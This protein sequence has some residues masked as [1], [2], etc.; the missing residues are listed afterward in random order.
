MR[1]G[2][3]TNGASEF[4]ELVR[5]VFGDAPSPMWRGSGAYEVPT[6][7]FHSDNELVIRMD[8]PDVRAEDVEVTVQENVLLINGTRSFPHDLEKVRW[9]RRGCFYGDFTQRVSL[10]KGLDTE[11]IRARYENGV[12]ELRIPYAPEVQPRKIEIQVG[13]EQRALN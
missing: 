9:V 1:L 5:R 4:D 2:T 11:N 13:D 8:L 10:G 6:D 12:L 3:F 7:V